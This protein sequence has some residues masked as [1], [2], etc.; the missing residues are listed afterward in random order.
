MRILTSIPILLLCLA[1][2]APYWTDG[3]VPDI[4]PKP[5]VIAVVSPD[6]IPKV[7]LDM[8]RSLDSPNSLLPNVR[9]LLESATVGLMHVTRPIPMSLFDGYADPSEYG[10]PI[11]GGI[12]AEIPMFVANEP[13]ERIESG[14]ISIQVD[15]PGHG[16]VH[17]S[18]QIPSSVPVQRFYVNM[19]D[20]YVGVEVITG[21]VNNQPVVMDTLL[22][23]RG[24]L[25]V[26]IADP[27]NESNY[28]GITLLNKASNRLFAAGSFAVNLPVD[29]VFRFF[30]LDRGNSR[31]EEFQYSGFVVFSDATFNGREKTLDIDVAVQFSA[32]TPPETIE[33]SFPH[34]IL[35]QAISKEYY[36]YIRSSVAQLNSRETPF[37]EPVPVLSNLSNGVGV[38]GAYRTL[39]VWEREE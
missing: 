26:R 4:Q 12:G 30:S 15:V 13:S 24:K 35:I 28:Y 19:L 1:C 9:T 37:S 38:L 34:Q 21:F 23:Y 11:W 6:S 16:T 39:H 36:E 22:F 29:P 31:S 8:T 20:T 25:S 33:L 32:S 3:T 7:F 2:E 10:D 18:T 17:G 27:A 14:R 5:V